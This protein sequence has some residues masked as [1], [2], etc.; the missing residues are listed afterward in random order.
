MTGALYLYSSVYSVNLACDVNG[1][2]CVAGVIIRAYLL[3][4]F[5]GKHG[6]ADYHLAVHVI[7]AQQLYRVLH[8]FQGRGHQRGKSHQT[9]VVLYRR[10]NNR[11]IIHVLA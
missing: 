8:A 2:F 7:L 3:G 10:V 11:L 1:F 5:G 6:A 4:I 9:D